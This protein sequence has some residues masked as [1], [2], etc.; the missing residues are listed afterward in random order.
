MVNGC[1]N[2]VSYSI[3]RRNQL[4][5][6]LHICAECA[7]EVVKA[8]GEAEEKTVEAEETDGFV[9]PVCGKVY[10]T[11]NGLKKHMETHS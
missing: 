8:A 6:S 2:M 10:K 4:G 7:K 9:C 1:R 3:T 5:N 11:E